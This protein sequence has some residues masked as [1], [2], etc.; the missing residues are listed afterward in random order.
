[1]AYLGQ[2]ERQMIDTENFWRC[3]NLG[4]VPVYSH[5]F[6]DIVTECLGFVKLTGGSEQRALAKVQ[7]YDKATQCKLSTG[8]ELVDFEH[9]RFGELA[10][11]LCY[12]SLPNW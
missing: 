10:H 9:R 4:M 12:V 1:M 3:I 2:I 11:Q 6:E 5:G 7:A 8:V